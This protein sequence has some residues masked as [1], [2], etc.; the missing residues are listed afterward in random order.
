MAHGLKLSQSAAKA[1]LDALGA[2]PDSGKLRV[3]NGSQ[4]ADADTAV[5]GQTKL[6]EWDL[7]ANVF[8]AATI[9]AVAR[10]IIT[11]NTVTDV[12]G[13]AAGT[14]SWFRVIDSGGNSLWDGTVGTSGCDLNLNTTTIGVGAAVSIL[15]WTMNLPQYSGG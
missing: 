14:A 10:A 4:P 11:A 9:G 5:S 15:S 2:L 3:Y 6:V 7:P 12:V 1:A 13:L 8:P